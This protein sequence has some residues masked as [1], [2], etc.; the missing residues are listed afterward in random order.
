[1]FDF[2]LLPEN[3]PFS[4]ALLVMLMIGAA[5]AIGLGAGAVHVDAHADAHAEGGDLLAWLGIGVV[6]LLI[7]LVVLLAWFALIGIGL[8]Q[9]AS[10]LWGAPLSPWLAAPAALVAALPLT[11]IGARALAR[12]LPGDETTAISLQALVGRRAEIVVGEARRGSPA[13]GRVRDF[14]GQT[15]YVMVEPTDEDGRLATGETALL[16][17]REGELFFGLPDI[18]PLHAAD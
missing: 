15:H 16:V 4:V 10:S 5:E 2:F 8:Q 7:V 11:G 17:R 3:L 9:L 18:H 6:P 13:R 14:H 1:V 12:L